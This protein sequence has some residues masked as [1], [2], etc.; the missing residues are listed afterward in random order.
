MAIIQGTG[1][2]GI[3]TYNP[4][5]ELEVD[6]TIIAKNIKLNNGTN[7]TDF[8]DIYVNE[9]QPNSITSPMI[10]D[11]SVNTQDLANG[12][13]T[14]QKI[15]DG[16]ITDID[17]NSNFYLWNKNGNNIYSNLAGNVGIGTSTPQTKFHISES[18]PGITGDITFGSQT[19]YETMAFTGMQVI[20]NT[21]MKTHY[22]VSGASGTAGGMAVDY[23]NAGGKIYLENTDSFVLRGKEVPLKFQI[24]NSGFIDTTMII[25]NS[26]NVGIGTYTPQAKLHVAGNI[27]AN[28][29]TQNNHVAT[30]QYV[31]S[32]AG[33]VP[34]PNLDVIH[35]ERTFSIITDDTNRESPVA[36][37]PAG[38]KVINCF[39]H[40]YQTDDAPGGAGAD[41]VQIS[42][43]NK[44]IMDSGLLNYHT[45]MNKNV[46]GCKMRYY[47]ATGSALNGYSLKYGA[48]CIKIS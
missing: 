16:T 4:R 45:F 22:G 40:N 21:N 2:V 11:G 17:I 39:L 18:G 47:G 42:F 25:T 10:V 9:D 36:T 48:I 26:R 28:N 12:A 23:Q 38:T 6:G 5:A 24:E 27:I 19:N 3:A 33:S 43:Q 34:T 32:V 44:G 37:C 13:V 20:S 35:V 30:K 46:N 7:I 15:A 41:W 8:D 29:P 31:D 14:S 1:Y